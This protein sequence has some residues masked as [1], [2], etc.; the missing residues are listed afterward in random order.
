MSKNVFVIP[1]EPVGKGRPRA[2]AIGGFARMY[3]PQKTVSYE[4]RVIDAFARAGG[5]RLDGF[6]SMEL[7]ATFAL[8]QSTSAKKRKEM[9]GEWCQK[10]PDA[11]NLAKIVC[12]AL[13]GIAY[14]DDRQVVELIVRKR[15]GDDGNVEV[16]L[17]ELTKGQ[18]DERTK[19]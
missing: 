1:G 16:R 6:V 19:I 17:S 12:D 4:A 2:T 11:D 9:N 10:K 8:P 3:T 14:E 15:W 18:H 7:T 13:N 5:K